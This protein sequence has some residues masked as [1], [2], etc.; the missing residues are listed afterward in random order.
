MSRGP[1]RFGDVL[2][3]PHRFHADGKGYALQAAHTAA[4]AFLGIDGGLEL[5]GSGDL[6]HLDC[7]EHAPLDTGLTSDAEIL[8]HFCLETTLGPVLS[9]VGTVGVDGMPDHA[10]VD[11]AMAHDRHG[12]A[13]VVFPV[14]HETVFLYLVND[15]QRLPVAELPSRSSCDGVLRSP[16]ELEAV[17][18]VGMGAGHAEIGAALAAGA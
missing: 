7:I 17:D 16:V 18:I 3:R 8:I 12:H 10:A 1:T 6:H 5:L 2:R 15:L 13:P 11:A 4:E 9:D 14:V